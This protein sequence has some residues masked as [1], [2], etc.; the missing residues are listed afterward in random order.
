MI[1]GRNIL[2][3]NH[4]NIERR[5]SRFYKTK[6]KTTVEDDCQIADLE[7]AKAQ[8]NQVV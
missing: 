5:K 3:G 1:K 4:F 7:K 6:N 8:N 2:K